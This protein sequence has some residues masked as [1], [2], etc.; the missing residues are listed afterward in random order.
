MLNLGRGKAAAGAKAKGGKTKKEGSG[1]SVSRSSRAGLQFPVGRVHRHLRQGRYAAR[2]GAGA[3]VCCLF[4]FCFHKKAHNF[5]LLF[6]KQTIFRFTWP[7]CSS[8]WQQRFLNLLAMLLV[9]TR[10]NVL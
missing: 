8:I 10:N 4:V 9:I 7:L 3:P 1:K 6:V 5:K 2:V